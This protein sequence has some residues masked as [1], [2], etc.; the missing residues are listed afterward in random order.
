MLSERCLPYPL[1]VPLATSV[2]K[3][4]TWRPVLQLPL[5]RKLALDLCDACEGGYDS[6]NVSA[7]KISIGSFDKIDAKSLFCRVRKGR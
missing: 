7:K 6:P 3:A 1:V 4:V 2:L 5:L